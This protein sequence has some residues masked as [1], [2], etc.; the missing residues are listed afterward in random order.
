MK[1]L[2][3]LERSWRGIFGRRSGLWL[4]PLAFFVGGVVL[5]DER[6]EEFPLDLENLVIFVAI[7]FVFLVLPASVHY[8]LKR[9]EM[10]P[11]RIGELERNDKLE[12]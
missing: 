1:L 7:G 3:E 9:W 2:N 12:D 8:F 6:V 4:V 11:K 10:R 5:T